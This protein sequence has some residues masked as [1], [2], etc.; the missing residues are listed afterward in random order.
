MHA[1]GAYL[2]PDMHVY[3]IWRLAPGRRGGHDFGTPLL[4]PLVAQKRYWKP[5]GFEDQL[6]G[7]SHLGQLKPR[8]DD[9]IKTIFASHVIDSP[10]RP[11][12]TRWIE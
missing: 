7:C 5:Q 10:P 1:S 6:A 12:R 2:L 3:R 11:E 4:R 9:P 8:G